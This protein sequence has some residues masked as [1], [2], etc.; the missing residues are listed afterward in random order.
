[1]VVTIF[2]HSTDGILVFGKRSGTGGIQ[3][4]VIDTLL[5]LDVDYRSCG[6]KNRRSCEMDGWYE[7]V[8]F[9]PFEKGCLV[10][11]ED[12]D[13]QTVAS[14][15]RIAPGVWQKRQIC[16]NT[17]P[18][19]LDAIILRDS[20]FV[21][22]H[23]IFNSR[24]YFC[25]ARGTLDGSFIVDTVEASYDHYDYPSFA[26]SNDG[27]LW[28]SFVR[29]GSTFDQHLVASRDTAGGWRVYNVFPAHYQP[30]FPVLLF[31]ISELH[32]L[33]A[34]GPAVYHLSGW[35]GS[36]HEE[37]IDTLE[38]IPR[39]C[40]FSSDIYSIFCRAGYEPPNY[41]DIFFC[42]INRENRIC[43]KE[44]VLPLGPYDQV[45]SSGFDISVDD[46]GFVNAVANV[47]LADSGFH[48]LY[49]ARRQPVGVGDGDVGSRRLAN[50]LL[51]SILGQKQ[52]NSAAYD[53]SGRR[54]VLGRGS[55]IYI[56]PPRARKLIIF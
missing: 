23:T 33:R 5:G 44:V 53:I 19:I 51:S 43:E 3:W 26:V 8:S 32:F 49:Y 56:F 54:V 14:A 52:S 21:A 38:G 6:L 22:F 31:N 16:Q 1:M 45:I 55:G 28:V 13:C 9:L 7:S 25:V 18:S 15:R 41:R 47:Y 27:R 42:R 24:C 29:S 10:V 2:R 35:P 39:A 30:E 48:V 46:Y 17:H 20:L 11:Y 12:R 36:I 34:D 40:S 50:R 4:E 37:L